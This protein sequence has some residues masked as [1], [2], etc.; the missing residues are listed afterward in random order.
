M[1]SRSS[2]RSVIYFS[3]RACLAAIFLCF[4]R[5]KGNLALYAAGV[6]FLF[7]SLSLASLLLLS[8]RGLPFENFLYQY[9]KTLFIVALIVAARR[10][11]RNT[12]LARPLTV[13]A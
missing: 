1:I 2:S 3:S 7:L 12:A 8:R 13:T 4:S 10:M 6:A 11:D 5:G 9:W